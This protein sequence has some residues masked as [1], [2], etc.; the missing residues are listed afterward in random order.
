MA[1]DAPAFCRLFAEVLLHG[2]RSVADSLHGRAQLRCGAPE[3]LAPI[4]NL[5]FF[6]K[7]DFRC[8]L[9]TTLAQIIGHDLTSLMP[10]APGS[11][12]L[13]RLPD[14]RTGSIACR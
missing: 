9:R 14:G 1:A 7:A 11:V 12:P 4:L 8:I 10:A 2:G 13:K 3:L 6:G 5:P